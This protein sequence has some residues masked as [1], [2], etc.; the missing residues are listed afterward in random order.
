MRITLDPA[1]VR[2]GDLRPGMSVEPVIDTKAQ[3]QGRSAFARAE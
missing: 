2:T 3:A 1:S